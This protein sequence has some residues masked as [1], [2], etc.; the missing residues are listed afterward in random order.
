MHASRS[1]HVSLA[2]AQ[3]LIKMTLTPMVIPTVV[4]TKTQLHLTVNMPNMH[5][6][7]KFD[8][9]KD[10]IAVEE[11]LELMKSAMTQFDMTNQERV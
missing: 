5:Q 6:P 7:K 8:G 11:W 3:A 4:L 10:P 9:A 1:T 2:K